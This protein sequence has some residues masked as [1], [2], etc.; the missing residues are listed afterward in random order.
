MNLQ[1]EIKKAYNKSLKEKEILK[2]YNKSVEEISKTVIRGVKNNEKSDGIRL[3][4]VL[5][6]EKTI[7]ANLKSAQ[8]VQ[9][10]I[11]RK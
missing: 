6:N 10:F 1:K 5:N 9:L 4:K 3:D 8:W 11:K 7:K 2:A